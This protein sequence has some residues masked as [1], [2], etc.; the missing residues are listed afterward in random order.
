[1]ARGG[2]PNFGGGG[3]MN[4]LMKQAQKMQKQMQDMQEELTNKEFSATV[5]GGAVT[6]TVTGKKEIKSIKIKP[7]VVDPEDIEMLED[8]ILTACNQ[9]LKNA[10]EQSAE[11]M[12]KLTGGLNIPGMF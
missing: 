9:A 8:L 11:D 5:G 3:N 2:I 6:A 7:E 10:D 1:M 12:K 4:N